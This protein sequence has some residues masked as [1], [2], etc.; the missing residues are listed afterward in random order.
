MANALDS[1]PSEGKL[2]LLNPF[3]LAIFSIQFVDRDNFLGR[4]EYIREL[5]YLTHME[6]GL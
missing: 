2:Y 1:Y 3:K 4:T 5:F 6:A